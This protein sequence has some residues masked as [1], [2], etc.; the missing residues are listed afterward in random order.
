[1]YVEL[2]AAAVAKAS[3]ATAQ[4]CDHAIMD[5]HDT[6]L[7]GGYAGDSPYRWKLWAE[8]DA[9]RARLLALKSAEIKAASRRRNRQTEPFGC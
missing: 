7:V 3:R 9:Y 2:M 1:M 6:L 8:I 5:C 4:E